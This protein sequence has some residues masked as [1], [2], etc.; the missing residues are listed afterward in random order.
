MWWCMLELAQ[1]IKELRNDLELPISEFADLIAVSKSALYNYETGERLPNAEIL[2]DICKSTGVNPNW[3]LLGYGPK[4]MDPFTARKL[5]A[6]A[7][8]INDEEYESAGIDGTNSANGSKINMSA[9]GKNIFQAG[10]S[11]G[12]VTIK[13]TTKKINKLIKPPAGS[14]GDNPILVETITGLFNE[15]GERREKQYGKSSYPVMYNTFKKDFGI[16]KNQKY[17]TYKLWS[18]ERGQ[19]IIEYLKDKLDNTIKGRKQK[20]AK[21]KGHTRPYLLNE[22]SQLHEDLEWS[23]EVYR[24]RLHFLFGVTSR[25]DL[26]ISQ[27]TSY[28]EYLKEEHRL[29]YGK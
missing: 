29:K 6:S 5:S 10:G 14:I 19:E 8:L 16:P 28:V 21:R 12:N 24:G 27:L 22:S 20:A 3:L 25:R 15:L 9:E 26:N 18:E 23:A 17:T 7:V 11:I 2:A 13:S 4:K 1:R